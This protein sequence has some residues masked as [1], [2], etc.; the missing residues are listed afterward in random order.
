MFG[1]KSD[2]RLLVRADLYRQ[3]DPPMRGD[4]KSN[5]YHGHNGWV[6]SWRPPRWYLA[7]E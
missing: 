2:E 3:I 6:E 1:D 4:R 7:G 5:G